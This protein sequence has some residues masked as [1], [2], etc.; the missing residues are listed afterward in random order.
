MSQPTIHDA[1]T[2]PKEARETLEGVAKGF[3]FIPNILGLMAE[4]PAALKAY[5]AVDQAF[6][7]SSLSPVE[8]KTLSNYTNHIFDTPLDD[9]LADYRWE[10]GE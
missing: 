5:V 9:A 3:G 7:E 8:Q 10:A 2:A 1:Q 4:A 6:R